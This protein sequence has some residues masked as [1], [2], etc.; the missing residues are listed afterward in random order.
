MGSE[1]CPH[2]TKQCRMYC[3]KHSLHCETS[4]YEGQSA[5]PPWVAIPY[6]LLPTAYCLLPTAYCLLP[7]FSLVMVAST[8]LSNALALLTVS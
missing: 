1:R 4:A 8:E 2:N 7:G 5:A 3:T 6:C